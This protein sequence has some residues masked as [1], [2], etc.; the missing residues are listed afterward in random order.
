MQQ[1]NIKPKPSF[2]G[3]SLYLFAAKF[4]PALAIFIAT[5]YFSQRLNTEAYGQYQ[6]FWIQLF[7]VSAIGTIGFPIFALTYPAPKLLSI[8]RCI[9]GF[10]YF[11]F[12]VFLLC[13]SCIFGAFQ[14]YTNNSDLIL[15]AVFLALYVAVALSDAILIVFKSFKALISLNIVYSLLFLLL[16]YWKVNNNIPFVDFLKALSLLYCFRLTVN[17][18]LIK[19]NKNNMQNPSVPIE[20]ADWLRIKKLWLQLGLNDIIQV[21]FRWVDKFILSF[22]LAKE[23]FAV[24]TNA[25]IEIAFLPLIFSAVSSAAVQHW[26]HQQ[27]AKSSNSQIAVLHYSS[28]IL[29]SIVFP[30]FFFLLFFREEFLINIFSEKYISG[31]WIFVCAQLVLPV[32]AYPFTALLQSHH[33][34]DIINKGSLIDFILACILMYPLYLLMGLPGVA[35]SF[36]ISTYW[37]A[38]YYLKHTSKLLKIPI[39]QLIPMGALLRKFAVFALVFGGAYFIFAHTINNTKIIFWSGMSLLAL[40]GSIALLY[41]WNKNTKQNEHTA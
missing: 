30:L 22:I 5:L 17:V 21:L 34:G 35:L 9:S 20:D 16:H 33:R 7:F 3:N 13:L 26:A 32:R 24:Y 37:Q 4:F 15:S 31:V 39:A 10:Q 27:Q 25:T 1:E 14:F 18:V 6:N 8:F 23:L 40:C 36:V 41:E 12:S 28:A 11:I 19:R 2:T 29:S 38:G